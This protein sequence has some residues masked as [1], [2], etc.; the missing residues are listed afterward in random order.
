MAFSKC[1]H[2]SVIFV[3]SIL[4]NISKVLP[5][6]VNLGKKTENENPGQ[7]RFMRTNL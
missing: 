4:P 1:G 7:S 3:H 5:F 2:W 6:N